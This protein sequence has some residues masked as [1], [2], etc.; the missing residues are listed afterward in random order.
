MLKSFAY[1][2][3]SICVVKL[4]F[5]SG[6]EQ[7]GKNEIPTSC[8][9]AVCELRNCC[10]I[11]K[12]YSCVRP[13]TSFCT[14][15]CLCKEGYLRDENGICIPAAQCPKLCG[16]NEIPTSCLESVCERRNCSEI[17]KPY[18]CVRMD[19]SF[20]T[21]GC[22][23][24]EG[25]LRDD[26]GVCV[27]ISQCPRVCGKN[28]IPTSCFEGICERRNC[29]DIGKPVIC[30]RPRFCTDGC[31]CKEGY[32][33]DEYGKCIPIA[34]CPNAQC[35]TNEI[36]DECPPPCPGEG[37][38]V[39]PSV[40][41]CLTNPQPGDP[42]CNPGCRCQDNYFRN[43]DGCCV[44]RD[45]CP[46]CGVNE[47]Y[48]TCIAPCPP[49]RCDVDETLLDCVS[50]PQPGDPSCNAGCRCA[51]NFYRN[52]RNICVPRNECPGQCGENEIP[53]SC[54]E[55]ICER[56]SCSDLG[57]P[58]ICVRPS[59]CTNGCLCKEGYLRD[60]YGKCIP[61]AQ[62]P[63]AQCGTNEIFDECPPPCPG[64]GCRVDP[65]VTLCLTNPLPGDPSCNPGCRCQ[66][67]YF[68]NDDGCCVTRDQCPVCGVNEVYDTCI[69][70]CPPRTCGVNES[71]IRCESPPQPGDPNCNAG[72]RCADNFYRNDR[73]VCVPRNEC[74]GQ[75]GEN[76]IPTSCFEGICERR[77][78]S[79]LGKPVICVRPSVCTN[80]CL[81]KEGYLRDENGICIPIAQ[82]PNIQCGTNEIF[83]V[84]PP[85]CPGEDCRVDPSLILCVPNPLPGDPR[86]NPGCRCQDNYFRNDDGCCVTRDQCPKCNG[87]NEYFSCG[88]ACDNVCA[89]LSTQN[90]TNCPIINKK[91]NPKCYCQE[92]YARD[93][94]NICIPIEDCPPPVCGFN[95]VYDTCIA[96][97]P[98]RRCDVNETLIR[99]ESP[100]QPGDPSC[101]AGCRCAD[102]FYRNDINVC[103]PRN[104]CP[105]EQPIICGPDEIYNSCI[106]GGCDRRNCSQPEY[107]C[108]LVGEEG[109]RAGCQ[110]RDGYLRADD[111]SCIPADQCPPLC[112]IN[113]IYDTCPAS[114]PPRTCA[115][116]GIAFNCITPLQPGDVGC[117]PGCRC[118]DGYYRNRE[119]VCIP[120]NQCP[121]PVI[122]GADEVYDSCVN[123]GCGRWNCSQP[124][125]ICINLIKGGCREG[126][127]CKEGLLRAD[128]GTCIPADQCPI[129]CFGQNEIRGCRLNC[130]P[131]T[132]E[133]I[134]KK[135]CCPPQT[136][137][138][139]EECRC[140][141]GFFRNKI[142]ECISKEDCLK[143]TGP[144]EYFSCGGACDNVCATLATQSQ[145]NC[146]IVNVVCN[147][148]CYCEQGYARDSNNTCVPISE[149]PQSVC[150]KNEVFDICPATCPP[151]TCV[152][153][154]RAYKCEAPPTPGDPECEPSCRCADGYYRNEQG[155]CVSES[156]CLNC[157]QNEVI[158]CQSTCPPQTCESI[159]KIYPCPLQPAV[160]R[161]ECR[162]KEDFFRNKIGQCISKEDCLK[163]TGPNEYFSCGGACDN[164]C[165]TLATQSQTNCSIVNVVC[166]PMC[167][168]EQGYARDSNNTCV[169]I[170]ECPQPIC[171]KNEIFDECPAT[172]P[173]RTCVAL[174]RAYKCEA[175][176]KPG[177]SECKPSCRCAD[178]Y[179]RNKQGVCV[180][181]N[182]CLNCFGQNEVIGCQNTCSP[183][184][185]ESIGKRYNCPRQP[186]VC[187]PECRCKNDFFRNK[188]GQCISNEDCLKCTGP[189]EYFSC[190]GACDNVCAT[191]ATQSQTNCS[192]VN[193][194]CNPMC[195]CE[196]GYA[197]DS[198]NTCVPISECP[199]PICGKNEVFDECPA[200][201]PPRTC[202]ALGRDYKCKAPPK[203]GDPECK[204]SCRCADGYYRNKQDICVP[205]NKC[206]KP[207]VCGADEVYNSCVNGGCG[208]WNCSQPG[209]ICIDL[210][211]GACREGCRCKEGLLRSDDG[212]CIPADQCPINCFGQN[213]I[214]GCRLNC[215]PQTCE[216]I[217]KKYCCP[218]Q[219]KECREE[220][221]CKE[222]FFRNK[223]NECISKEDCLKC[224]G[225]NEYFSCGGACDNVCATL[226]TQSQTNCSIVNV[227][228]N[229]M[230]YCEQGYARDSNNT[231]VPISKCPQPP[232]CGK[233]EIYDTCPPIC[234]PQRCDFDP[235]VSLC[236][237]NPKPGNPQCKPGCRC[238]DNYLRN[239][240]NEC[241]PK[242]Q[243]DN[244]NTTNELEEFEQGNVVFTLKFMCEAANANPGTSLIFSPFSVLFLLAQLAFYATGTLLEQLLRILNL[245]T[246]PKIRNVIPNYLDTLGSQQNITLDLAAKTY[247]NN[248]YPLSS[249]F[250]RDT[251]EIFKAKAQNLDFCKQNEA[252]DNI[253][254]WV[255]QQTNNLIKDLVEP[256]SLGCDTA[257][258]L[259]NA[260][261]FKGDWKNKFD[262]KN[263]RKQDFY[264]N[265]DKNVQV[266]MMSRTGTYKYAEINNLGAQVIQLPY[267]S[268][269][270]SFLIYLPRDKDGINDLIG[271]LC[272]SNFSF[273]NIL[274]NL[275]PMKTEL[276]MP[277]FNISTTTDLKEILIKNNASAL[278]D[279]NMASFTG[280]LENPQPLYVSSATQKATVIVN[281]SGSIAAAANAV[282]V[283]VTSVQQSITFIANHPF[284]YFILYKKT[285]IFCGMYFANV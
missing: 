188:I 149:C 203:P 6:S 85:Q 250:K 35:G 277:A 228:C 201:C 21:S 221:R 109:C 4:V 47:V 69:A 134:G 171:G 232:T 207:V 165:A 26:N 283:S 151:R 197:R 110:C 12:P 280:I 163:C 210:I 84:C 48:D 193:V 208:R 2:T 36:F 49:R 127:R 260:I 23:C 223:I 268:D 144:N 235:R 37:C 83:D 230:C 190:G 103:V 121:K 89:T 154:G 248:K 99:C 115:T 199:Q 229:P 140:K 191:L 70:P 160:C 135:Y 124:G 104:E 263:T 241:I 253:N 77:S 43:D 251:R 113:E 15:G 237:P 176:P 185:C 92:A 187:K 14:S 62:C 273:S 5:A 39:D 82:C 80:G 255:E 194:V 209:I 254:A 261:Y 267:E 285:P 54:F 169:P 122:C 73:N 173:P 180:P 106:N 200:T 150:G 10:D 206:P 183:Q 246:Q 74:P 3:I 42:T 181:E 242:D 123:G 71:L 252:A 67:N 257:I 276:T 50:P 141:K 264:V 20:C 170:S 166:N 105:G 213:E 22:L 158:G 27:R 284:I 175:P 65:S 8:F 19:T 236:A 178:G 117:K 31:L 88:S 148:M 32:L 262:P 215:P 249:G 192:I 225:P 224:T 29:S 40:T 269:N 139:R 9:E 212:T 281:E 102:N 243:C 177:D 258:V 68:R 202:V 240:L 196:Q 87:K 145:T 51:D 266:D 78:C 94:N 153:L 146:S 114:C 79:D 189:N 112:G 128:D 108:V 214:R 147:P 63:N 38:R 136:K 172:C 28:E 278:F 142:G 256:S 118:I 279:P 226:A 265:K 55:G 59:V 25:Y 116:L 245:D 216:S 220:C 157:G 46:V 24:K 211:K 164:V 152:A 11:G 137:E 161:P 61:I 64:E 45:Q 270:F 1:T 182:E 66:D 90:Q 16:K 186:A 239:S 219:T 129:N 93:N 34:Q 17:G 98:P 217:G 143:C 44:T 96:P 198:N 174:G 234:P 244:N 282:V 130:P 231:C 259:V 111:G 91:C 86:C 72:C 159:G 95:E 195:Y 132:C 204:P 60:E 107:T 233:N 53:T 101:N 81:C 7:C 120:K 222:G 275:Y 33:R 184:T 274:D 75:C 133:S 155:A 271:K 56:R 41:L 52:D 218:P 18:S 168:C 57:K 58:V 30:V 156:E 119:G 247:A 272:D 97:C 205:K 131:Q 125:E 227:V 13:D 76:E 238:I 138:C 126:C 100:P 162:C 167:Y 179:Y